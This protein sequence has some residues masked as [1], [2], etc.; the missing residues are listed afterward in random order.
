M[1]SSNYWFINCYVL[2]CIV[3]DAITAH[4]KAESLYRE[5]QHGFMF[6]HSCPTN[7]LSAAKMEIKAVDDDDGV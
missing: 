4:L 3:S 1:N 2:E 5:A 6:D 7:L